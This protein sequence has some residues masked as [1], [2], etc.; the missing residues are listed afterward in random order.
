MQDR[1]EGAALRGAGDLSQA[2]QHLRIRQPFK[3]DTHH[4]RTHHDSPCL[5][6]LPAGERKVEAVEAAKGIWPRKSQSPAGE[7]PRKTRGWS[8][9]G[10]DT[11]HAR[12]VSWASSRHQAH[13]GAGASPLGSAAESLEPPAGTG[14]GIPP[15]RR[16]PAHHSGS[17]RGWCLCPSWSWPGRG[18]ESCGQS[19]CKR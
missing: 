19:C 11:A 12:L 1:L 5:V 14:K 3:R 6:L 4:D 2:A 15:W 7:G 18:I 16:G 13:R 10:C 9:P 8:H 17:W